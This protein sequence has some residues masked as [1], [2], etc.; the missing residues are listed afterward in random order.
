MCRL[1]NHRQ[2]LL[3]CRAGQGVSAILAVQQACC[4]ARERLTEPINI[5]EGKGGG[6]AHSMD[7]AGKHIAARLQR[8]PAE[9]E[10]SQCCCNARRVQGATFPC[11]EPHSN[12]QHG[13]HLRAACSPAVGT[14]SDIQF[15]GFR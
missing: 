9:R 1:R 10:Q 13:T 6:D 12:P 7:K 2:Q 5:V 4:Q 11:K 14:G 15:L 3:V 8:W